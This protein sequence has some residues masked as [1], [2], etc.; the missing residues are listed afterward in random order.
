[1]IKIPESNGFRADIDPENAYDA[2]KDQADDQKIEFE[3]TTALDREHYVDVGYVH[4]AI[5]GLGHT[6]YIDSYGRPSSL[7]KLHDSLADPKYAGRKITRALGGAPERSESEGEDEEEEPMEHG[8][9]DPSSSEAS[10]E[11]DRGVEEQETGET[12]EEEEGRPAAQPKAEE[13][14]QEA[15]EDVSSSLK[16]MRDADRLKGQ[17]VARQMVREPVPN[18]PN[19]LICSE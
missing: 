2:T 18:S 10:E 7:R 14:R 6:W 16:R 12:S 11:E 9:Y 8:S 19:A 5:S 17:A 3:D 15:S 1:M 13:E 4:A